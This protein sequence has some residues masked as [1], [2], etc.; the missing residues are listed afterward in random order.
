M[1]NYKTA[2][3]DDKEATNVQELIDG[4]KGLS[5]AEASTIYVQTPE[6]N[7][8]KLFL[9]EETLTDGSIAYTIIVK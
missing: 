8:V 6:G 1:R 5:V 7:P 3:I 2:I 9:M 4:L